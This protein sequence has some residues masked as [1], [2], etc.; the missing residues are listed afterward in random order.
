MCAK[1]APAGGGDIFFLL[2]VCVS[3]L[4]CPSKTKMGGDVFYRNIRL[5]KILEM[6][7]EHILQGIKIEA[8]IS[9]HL[10]LVNHIKGKG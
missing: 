1:S 5:L 3:H 7:V 9:S 6:Q 10:M 8:D 4:L 2:C